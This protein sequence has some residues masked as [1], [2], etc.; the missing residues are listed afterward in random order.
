MR[1]FKIICILIL[2]LPIGILKPQ[3]NYDI[4]KAINTAIINNNNIISIRN[5][6]DIQN[7]NNLTAKGNL[8]PSLSLSTGWT[9][10]NSYYKGGIIYQNGIP[11]S[12][13]SQSNTSD[14]FSLG[15]N[16]QV[17]LFDGLANYQNL[18]IGNELIQSLNLQLEKYKKDIV[19]NMT[20]IFFD[21]VKKSKLSSNTE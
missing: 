18:E 7:L 17:V 13:N 5:N 11:V 10:N 20:Q 3:N 9:R 4:Q 6:I 21:V 1:K 8:I 2:L 12:V 19:I 15:L 16:S 14:N